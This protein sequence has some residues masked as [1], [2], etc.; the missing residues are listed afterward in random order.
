MEGSNTLGILIIT[1]F[2]VQWKKKKSKK[3]KM[4]MKK[5]E[6]SI[7]DRGKRKEESD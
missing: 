4:K 6:W 5:L 1:W 7:D 3:K 2:C